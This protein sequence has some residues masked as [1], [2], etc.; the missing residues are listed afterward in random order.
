VALKSAGRERE[1]AP[2]SRERHSHERKGSK[3]TQTEIIVSCLPLLTGVLIAFSA[4]LIADKAVA[5]LWVTRELTLSTICTTNLL[6]SSV[7]TYMVCNIVFTININIWTEKF[8]IYIAIINKTYANS[9][10]PSWLQR[11]QWPT[12]YFSCKTATSVSYCPF[13]RLLPARPV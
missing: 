7:I 12:P 6:I 5:K 2:G 13:A 9:L 1:E 10:S 4:R 3:A 11:L 8:Y